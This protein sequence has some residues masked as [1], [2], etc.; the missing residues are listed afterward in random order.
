MMHTDIKFPVKLVDI[1]GQVTSFEDIDH[2]IC[3]LED[4]D[5][6]NEPYDSLV[7]SNGNNLRL[8]MSMMRIKIFKKL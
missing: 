3:N 5:S 8:E 6:E 1:D 7:D 2:L 4:F